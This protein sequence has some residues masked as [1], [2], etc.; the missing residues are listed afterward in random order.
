MA[1][2]QVAQLTMLGF[3]REAALLA[4]QDAEGDIEVAAEY[5]MADG[6]E[7]AVGGEDDEG[8][9]LG[10]AASPRSSYAI[11]ESGGFDSVGQAS[12][13]SPE[14]E[15]LDD[16]D[17][18]Y[19]LREAAQRFGEFSAERVSRLGDSRGSALDATLDSSVVGSVAGSAVRGGGGGDVVYGR[20]PGSAAEAWGSSSV[21][22]GAGRGAGATPTGQMDAGVTPDASSALPPPVL[23]AER[24]R[25]STPERNVRIYKDLCC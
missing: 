16:D 25:R 11:D 5:L 17:D 20:T 14:E 4:L 12:P 7:S 10:V 24:R 22:R 13:V 21:M 3:S 6:E 19:D 9:E 23:R 15:L 8:S 2:E 18:E 1:E